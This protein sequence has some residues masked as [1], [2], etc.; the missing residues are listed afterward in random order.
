MPAT[1]RDQ[2]WTHNMEMSGMRLPQS[3]C[4]RASQSM[5]IR[6]NLPPLR[7]DAASSLSAQFLHSTHT[8]EAEQKERR[9]TAALRPQLLNFD[10]ADG[11]SPERVYSATGEAWLPSTKDAS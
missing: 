9:S 4:G 2:G 8:F 6:L 10:K 5:A 11:D 3:G 7:C 1:D